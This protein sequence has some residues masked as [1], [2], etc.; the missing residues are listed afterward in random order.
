MPSRPVLTTCTG[1]RQPRIFDA[2]G[3]LGSIAF[4]YNIVIIPEV[5]VRSSNGAIVPT[6]FGYNQLQPDA[7]G[8][9]THC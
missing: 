9:L 4:A 8:S 5:Q 6:Q 2:L 1:Q 3:A 7:C